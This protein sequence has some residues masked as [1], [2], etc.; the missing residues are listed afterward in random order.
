Y[1]A[2]K[3]G[4]VSTATLQIFENVKKHLQSYEQFCGKHITFSSFDFDFYDRFIRFLSFDYIQPRFK[5]KIIGLKANTVGKTIKQLKIFLKDRIKRKI[6]EPIDL[7]DYKVPD[8]AS[9]AIYLTLDEISKLY[10]TDLSKYPEL[11]IDRN[12][13]VFACLT[14]L[15]FSDFSKLKAHDLRQGLLYK[16]Q[17]KSDQWVVIPL[18]REAEEM[19]HNLF[20]H[21]LPLSSNPEF[22][23]NIKII[24]KL[25][26]I[27]QLITFSHKKGSKVI[28]VTKAKC[29]W[30]TAHTARRSFCTNEFL[31]GTPVKLIMQISGHRQEKDFY[32]YIKISPEQ[33]A[34]TMKK[35][36]EERNHLRAFSLNGEG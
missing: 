10:R 5:K 9:D 25:A 15:R 35:I 28:A 6:I 32:R 27:H 24:G 13:F 30:I 36:W 21:Q 14:G 20:D 22:N 2:A 18:R 7:S 16:K 31:A 12:C 29:D 1:I 34:E 33:A 4:K 8:E 23:R 3:K 17:Q 11:M 19:L 26:G